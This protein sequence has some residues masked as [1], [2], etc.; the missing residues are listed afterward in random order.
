MRARA[1]LGD[2]KI[3]GPH[4]KYRLYRPVSGPGSHFYNLLV[5]LL[6]YSETYDD[7]RLLISDLRKDLHKAALRQI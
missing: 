7:K 1:P 3:V 4:T 6:V 2:P 5:Y